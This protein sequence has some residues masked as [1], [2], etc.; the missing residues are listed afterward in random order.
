MSSTWTVGG[1]V[2]FGRVQIDGAYDYADSV[3]IFSLSAVVR[4]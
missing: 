1:S 4:F 3:K 2:V